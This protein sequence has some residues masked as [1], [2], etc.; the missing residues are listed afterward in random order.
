MSTHPIMSLP[1]ASIREPAHRLR[2]SIE[3]E[4]LGELADDIAANGLH[5][6]IGARGPFDDGSWEIVWGHRRYLAHQL[7]KRE[8]IEA[9][10]FPADYDPLDAAAAENLN[11][12]QLAPMDEARL[13]ARY[14]DRGEPD[15]AIARVLR[16]SLSWVHQRKEMLAWPSDV[17]AAV[18]DG[19]L[20]IAAGRALS[21]IDHAEYRGSLIAEAARTGANARTIDVWRAHYLADRARIE[22]NHS[23]IAEIAAS[24]EN[25][26]LMINCE[27]CGEPHD[28]DKTRSVRG[29]EPCW[30]A[31]EQLMTRAASQAE[32]TPTT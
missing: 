17:Q 13:V 8:S 3:P 20:T 10:T 15:S 1:L 21:D 7:L 9:R 30:S 4:P 31:I 25:W 26:R 22:A 6:P 28:Y 16:R 19:D 27:F 18:N 23:T 5:Q 12:V 32:P 29:C 24:R 11:R 2:E 14:V